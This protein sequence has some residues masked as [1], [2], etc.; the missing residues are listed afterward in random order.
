M[1]FCNNCGTSLDDDAVFCTSCGANLS[2]ET[3]NVQPQESVNVQPQENVTAQPQEFN[4]AYTQPQQMGYD[5]GGQEAFN[6]YG[7]MPVAPKKKSKAPLIIGICAGAVALV[8]V[9]VV[10]LLFAFGVLGSNSPKGI[11]EEYMEAVKELDGVA[12]LDCMAYSKEYKDEIKEMKEEAKEEAE[13]MGSM[14]S[15]VEIDY[16]ID[17]IEKASAKEKKEFWEEAEDYGVMVDKKDVK[18]LRI[19]EVTLKMSAMGMK[20]ET[21]MTLY[22]GKYKGDWK[23]IGADE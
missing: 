19:C 22:V 12:A 2:Q 14:A 3:V 16:E 7:N 21:E 4:Q 17:D 13:G 18:D 10:V 8:A 1:K 23:I 20:E 6:S 9:V 11:V 15:L 5:M